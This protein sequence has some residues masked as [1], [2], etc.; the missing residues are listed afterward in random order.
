MRNVSIG[1]IGGADGP[2][3][4]FVT[5]EFQWLWILLAGIAIAVGIAIVIKILKKK[6]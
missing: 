1:I 5:G 2:T 6:K 3:V 4:V